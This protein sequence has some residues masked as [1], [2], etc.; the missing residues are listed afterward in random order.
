MTGSCLQTSVSEVSQIPLNAAL[1][2][3]NMLVAKFPETDENWDPSVNE[4]LATIKVIFKQARELRLKKRKKKKRQSD[5][6]SYFSSTLPA[7]NPVDE[8][9]KKDGT[10]G[11]RWAHLPPQHN[12]MLMFPKSG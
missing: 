7:E 4:Q 1:P 2:V 10:H 9:S 8:K 12:T 11:T 3:A 5:S 6:K